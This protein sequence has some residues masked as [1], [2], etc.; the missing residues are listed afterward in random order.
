MN[1]VALYFTKAVYIEPISWKDT[2]SYMLVKEH[3]E[4]SIFSSRMD[5]ENFSLIDTYY[6]GKVPT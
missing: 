6:R 5:Q 3:I 4:R 2:P 1:A